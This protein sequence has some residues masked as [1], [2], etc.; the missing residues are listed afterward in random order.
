VGIGSAINIVGAGKPAFY[1]S[2]DEFKI[3]VQV[4]DTTGGAQRIDVGYQI[5]NMS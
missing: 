3:I 2:I 4:S 5:K 1:T